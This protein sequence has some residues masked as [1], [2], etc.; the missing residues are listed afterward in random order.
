MKFIELKMLDVRR[1]PPPRMAPPFLEWKVGYVVASGRGDRW[2][3]TDIDTGNM[4]YG[5]TVSLESVVFSDETR[6]LRGATLQQGY[7]YDSGDSAKVEPEWRTMTMAVEAIRNFY[8]RREGRPGTRIMTT[9]GVAY[10]VADEYD[11]VRSAVQL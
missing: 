3:I 10:V 7:T 5:S 4:G 9:S 1:R 8:P 6:T 2:L 11:D